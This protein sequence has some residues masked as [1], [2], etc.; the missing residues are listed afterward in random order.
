MPPHDDTYDWDAALSRL[1]TESADDPRREVREHLAQCAC[2]R[3]L[4]VS[5]TALRRDLWD[6]AEGRDR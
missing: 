6:I 5:V 1:L 4:A 3:F 2:C